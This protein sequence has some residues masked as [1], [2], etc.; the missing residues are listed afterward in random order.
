MQTRAL[1][2]AVEQHASWIAYVAHTLKH[3]TD[4]HRSSATAQCNN[5]THHILPEY[6][7]AFGNKCLPIQSASHRS[8]T[9]VVC[10]TSS[11]QH[12]LLLPL[13]ALNTQA[14]PP[15]NETQV[16]GSSL[17]IIFYCARFE[18]LRLSPGPHLGILT[19]TAAA[20]LAALPATADL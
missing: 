3:L 18:T 4:I 12:L 14:A 20:C 10:L 11:A 19:L 2:Q 1:W 16:E 5:T 7:M 15:L 6:A 8:Q 9:A 17:W 13:R